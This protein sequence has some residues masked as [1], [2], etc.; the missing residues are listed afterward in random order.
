MAFVY[1]LQLVQTSLMWWNCFEYHSIYLLC[2]Y[3]MS[4]FSY[5]MICMQTK[6]NMYILVNKLDWTFLSPSFAWGF[7]GTFWWICFFVPIS[8]VNT[9]TLFGKRN[10]SCAANKTD[11]GSLLACCTPAANNVPGWPHFYFYLFWNRRERAPCI[12]LPVQH[13]VSISACLLHELQGCQS[14]LK[15]MCGLD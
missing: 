13:A 8:N 2:S 9:L 12:T 14:S 6:P 11:Q 1:W 4:F 15:S 5:D 10:K 3:W 7:T